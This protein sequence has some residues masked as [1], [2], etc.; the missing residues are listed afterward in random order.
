MI[1]TQKQWFIQHVA[2]LVQ[3]KIAISVIK[4]RMLDSNR[5]SIA[6]IS[7]YVVVKVES[8]RIDPILPLAL[9]AHSE[10]GFEFAKFVH[11]L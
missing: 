3:L 10:H 8:T 11:G 9:T 5:F 2:S 4:L 1:S 7:E 6:Q